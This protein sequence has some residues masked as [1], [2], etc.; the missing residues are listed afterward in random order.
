MSPTRR[1]AASSSSAVSRGPTSCRVPTPV[2]PP[3]RTGPVGQRGQ[4]R[5]VDGR[6]LDGHPAGDDGPDRGGVGLEAVHA[7]CLAQQRAPASG[8]GRDHVRGQVR[9][10]APD[11][12]DGLGVGGQEPAGGLRPHRPVAGRQAIEAGQVPRL[13]L[14]RPSGQRRAERVDRPVDELPRAR[15]LGPRR[16]VR[17][18]LDHARPVRSR[19]GIEDTGTG[20]PERLDAIR[21]GAAPA[22]FGIGDVHQP[23]HRG[24]HAERRVEMR[25]T[26]STSGHHRLGTSN[27]AAAPRYRSAE[28]TIARTVLA[29]TE[30]TPAQC[31]DTA[32]RI[33]NRPP[34]ILAIR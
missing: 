16:P 7:R 19:R 10:V 30:V 21:H 15:R 14:H 23:Q 26:G 24:R 22:G 28:L 6:G 11:D 17:V 32:N 33:T 25:G 5:V 31:P 3:D 4:C 12:A 9:V 1:R 13:D 2:E 8:I 20:V 34:S 27:A 29:G 18:R